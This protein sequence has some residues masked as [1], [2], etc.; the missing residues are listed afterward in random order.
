MA[1]IQ[2]LKS[3]FS[4]DQI[5]TEPEMLS[6]YAKDWT[7][8]FKPKASA[9]VFPNSET[10]VIELVRLARREK[11]SL[12]PSGGRTGLSGGAVAMNNELVVSFDKM[13]RILEFNEEDLHLRVEAGAV[14]DQ[15]KE[16]AEEK[17]YFFPVSFASSGSSQLGGNAATNAGGVNVLRYGLTRNWVSGLN[18]VTGRGELLKLNH[19]LTKNATG[20]DIRHLMIGSEGTLG[21][22]TQLDLRLTRKPFDTKVIL[23]AIDD[24]ESAMK[25]FVR[26]RKTLE[27]LAFEIFDRKALEKVIERGHGTDPF[28]QKHRLHLIIE[29]EKP[30]HA[31][32]EFF[33]ESLGEI[34]DEGLA[35][36]G[37]ISSSSTQAKEL[38]ALRENISESI[39]PNK[40]YK[41]D[42]SVR[43]S[44]IP[45]FVKTLESEVEKAY[46]DF[47]VLWFGHIGDGNLH[48]NILK[49]DSLSIEKFVEHCRKVDEILFSCVQKLEGSISAEHGVG[50]TKKDFLRFT[51]DPAEIDLMKQIKKSFDPDGILNPGKI[52]NL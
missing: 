45:E 40:P 32:D 26:L 47:E 39:T 1:L 49:P 17:G 36:D 42:I 41:N 37:V 19:G 11:V 29:V 51:R 5:S 34:F 22:I 48:L 23:L 6:A 10:Q 46:P 2:T 20:Y 35:Q 13:N 44:R 52:F 14:T 8:Y 33:D 7:T 18:V 4:D 43:T 38:W 25:I 28:S 3:V 24:W 16:F 9:V 50:L 30:L 21:L 15:V 27:L 12:V 31:P